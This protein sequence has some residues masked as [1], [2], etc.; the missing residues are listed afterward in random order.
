MDQRYDRIAMTLHWTIALL[1]LLQF[2]SGWSW[3]WFERG[4]TGRF[5]LF[6]T[7]LVAGWAILALAIMRVIYRF[8]AKQP[9]LPA[10][11]PRL[12]RAAAH[13]SHG[14]LYLAILV[15]PLLGIVTVS[16]F[17]KTLGG[18]P[19][20]SHVALAWL[21]AGLVILHA[22]AALWHQFARRDHLLA[23]MLPRSL[24]PG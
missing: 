12:Q 15:Q 23:R 7:H 4:S 17:G 22:G 11:M 8:F 24:L 6:R 21:I 13:A 16:A 2:T 18:W 1:V 5:I 19:G 9:A 14:L 20:A 3:G 10:G